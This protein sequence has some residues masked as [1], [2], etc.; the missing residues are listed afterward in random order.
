MSQISKIETQMPVV[1][2]DGRAVGFVSSVGSDYLALTSVKDGRGYDHVI[3]L[4]WIAEV[5]RYVFL[6]RA[7]PYV[8]AHR[9]AVV[10]GVGRGPRP[11][12]A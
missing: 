5:D 6:S 10:R 12:A 8:V 11:M 7:S 9:H 4:S 2:A 1:A 3:P